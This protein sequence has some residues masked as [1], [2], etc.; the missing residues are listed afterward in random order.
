MRLS[1]DLIEELRAGA[2]FER[3]HDLRAVDEQ[4]AELRALATTDMATEAISEILMS[5]RQPLP[6]EVGEGLA[7]ALLQEYHGAIWPWNMARD[8][9]T[10]TASLPGADLVGFIGDESGIAFV[11]GEVKSSSDR[12]VPPAVVSGSHGLGGQLEKLCSQQGARFELVKWLG[13]R[14]GSPEHRRMF[15]DAARRYVASDGHDVRLIGCLLRD[16]PPHE[17]DLKGRALALVGSAVDPT[18]V[19]LFAWY[20]PAPMATWPDWVRI[21]D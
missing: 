10:P 13:F 15:E 21:D 19:H 17:N 6:W 16:T 2:L 11:F 7:E 14:R 9:R 4:A 1:H 8:R 20:V 5:G 18:T 3:V 12:R